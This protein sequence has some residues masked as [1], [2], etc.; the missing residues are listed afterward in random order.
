MPST[1]YTILDCYTDEPSGLGVPPFLGTYP[2]YLFGAL[3]DHGPA[4]LTIDDVRLWRFRKGVVPKEGHKTDIR[5]HNLSRNHA[6]VKEILDATDE[7]IVVA[8]VQTPGKYLA[9][10]PGTLFEIRR[11]IDGLR[12]RKTL[13]GPASTA[14]GTRA[15]GGRLPERTDLSFFDSVDA[16]LLGIGQYQKVRRYAV[17]G[18]RLVEQVPW[19]AVAELET[20]RGC[21]RRDACSFCT[22]P[23]HTLEWRAT[24][25]IIAE[26]EALAAAGVRHFRLGKQS[27]FYAYRGGAAG[28]VR[29]LLEGIRALGPATLHIDNVN[30]ASVVAANGERITRLI[31]EHCTPGNIAA[32]GVESFDPEVVGR[33]CLNTTPEQALEAIRIINLHGAERGENGMPKF[34]PGINILLGL[35]GETKGTLDLDL[36]WLKRILDEGLMLRRINIRQ[37]VPYRGTRL[38]AEAKTKYIKKNKAKYFSFRRKVREEVDLPML[39]RTVPEGTVLSGV[40]LETHDGSTTFGRQMGTY[41]LIV[42]IRRRLPL[43]RTVS[44]KVSSHMLRSLVAEVIEENSR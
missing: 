13:T 39:R 1:R 17:D 11:L 14:H 5:I 42:G 20:G 4:Y 9:A 12:C 31:V 16:D 3:A 41:P 6:R 15:E 19:P 35:I 22:E 44:V 30:P 37:V 7:L 24:D 2:R 34:L 36:A 33:N 18:A 32:F 28:E 26:A 21:P 29:K 43:G 38:Y 40:R 27:D 25:D 23:R 8:G 10:V